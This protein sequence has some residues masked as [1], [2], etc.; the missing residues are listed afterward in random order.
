M[1]IRPLTEDDKPNLMDL[2][3]ATGLFSPDD[4]DGMEAMAT[5]IFAGNADEGHFWLGDDA[6]PA[7]GGI[8]C[9]AY[10]GPE[11]F[12][13]PGIW[14]LFFI[15]AYPQDQGKGRG[16]KML[17]HIEDKLRAED[18]RLLLIETSSGDGF[19]LTRKFYAQHGYDEEARIRG[20]YGTEDKVIF[21]K[22]L[23]A[24]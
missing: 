4:L 24:S 14:N 19:E 17:R 21:R 6:G 7:A 8:R 2:A 5:A 1:T 13:A 11:T 3:K 18:G 12:A 22:D 20:F 23:T 15:G 9:A 16:S 10:C